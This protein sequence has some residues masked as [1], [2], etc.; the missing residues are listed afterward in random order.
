MGFISGA[1]AAA[2]DGGSLAA[3]A[4]PLSFEA[5]RASSS[6]EDLTRNG[7]ARGIPAGKTL[8]LAEL[9]GPG[10][11]THIWHTL[12]ADDL[13][14]GRSLV[15]RIYYDGSE[16]P[17]VQTPVGDFLGLGH[18]TGKAYISEP[19]QVVS[20]GRGRTCWWRMPFRKGIRITVSNDSPDKAVDSFYWYVDW[21]KLDTLPEDTPYFHAL[22]RQAF[23]AP[24][25]NHV[26][27]DTQGKGHYVGTVY[28]VHQM[29]TG[30][31]GEGD[32]FFYIDGAEYPPLRGTGTE[33]YFGDAWGFREFHGP[34]HGVSMYEGVFAGDRV[35]AYRWHVQDPIPFQES[36]RV[37]ME[38]R[39]SVFN[40]RS[41]TVNPLTFEIG[42]FEER[43]DWLSS[44]AFWYQH[45]AA[46]LTEA[47][48][49]V[50]ER[51][52]PYRVLPGSSL[53]YRADPPLLIIPMQGGVGYVPNQAEAQIEFDFEITEKGRYAVSA[54]LLQASMA[55][56]FQ[57][58]IDGEKI[59][60]PLDLTGPGFDPVWTSLDLHDL[61]PGTH[62]LR[63]ESHG[64]LPE[65]MRT[66]APRFFAL[67]LQSLILLRLEDMAG[68]HAVSEQLLSGAPK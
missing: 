37:E 41:R 2:D 13:F 26:L 5:G 49:P 12:A 45:P 17:S 19:V 62:T 4:R 47:L 1:V 24:P 31:F 8:V 27:L 66:L 54:I 36:I 38:H 15:L 48:P 53:K 55:G 58:F 40:D 23:P 11:I 6:N 7:D 65:G 56:R 28:S 22:Y 64:E 44:V 43:P 14:A 50:G 39:G 16:T 59:G 20:H 29:E 51:I 68:Y 67:G 34:W 63:F 61:D 52:A 35:T 21:R 18:G 32:D 3:L 9:E 10:E 46:A 30:W 25:G 60:G 57:P 42:T 33:D